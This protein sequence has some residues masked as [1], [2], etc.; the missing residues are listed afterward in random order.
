MTGLGLAAA[1]FYGGW[2]GIHGNVTL[3]HFMGFMAAAM[4]AFQPLKSLATTQATL[5]EGLLA[6]ARI[7]ALIDHASHVTEKPGAKPLQI[8]RGAISFRG[9][10]FAYED[11]G[12][13]LA[14]FNLEIAPGQK[15]ALVGLSGAGKS[16]VLDLILRFFDPVAGAILIDGQDLRDATLASVRGASALLTQDPVLFDDT[17][18]ANIAYGSETADADAI[19]HAADAAAA[20]DFIM[21]LPHGYDTQVGEAGPAFRRRAPAHRLCPRD[22]AQHAD[23]APRRADQRARRQSEAKVQAAMERLLSGRTVVMI[24]HRLSTVKKADMICFMEGGRIMERGTHD[25]LV[26]R[27]GKYARMFQT[28]LFG[29]EPKLAVAGG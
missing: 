15:V 27:R 7:F 5:S 8:T 20:H 1:I 2:Q 9:V 17:I 6:A 14:D 25:E 28:Q 10:D 24:A 21:R 11:S 13:I 16:T 26:A 18:G 19:A 12:R 29:E 3:G 22:A 4:L 23:P